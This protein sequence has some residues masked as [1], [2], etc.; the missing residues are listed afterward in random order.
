[1][2]KLFSFAI[3]LF[4][5]SYVSAQDKT[6]TMHEAVVGLYTN[7][8]SENIQQTT[9][10]PNEDAFTKIESLTDAPVLVKVNVPSM[11]TET[12]F[13]LTDINQSL[14]LAKE[15]RYIPQIHWFDKQSV[16]FKYGDALF[17]GAES[18]GEWQFK[19]WL[20]LPE[21]TT[22]YYV[23][24]ESKQVAYSKANNLM[25]ANA[26]GEKT[27]VTNHTDLNIVSGQIVSRNEF[28]VN[29]GVFFAPESNL[30]AFYQKD[31]SKVTNYPVINWQVVP[32]EVKMVK[33]PMAGQG[34]EEVHLG[35]YNPETGKTVFMQTGDHTDHYLTNITWGPEG[36]YI[37]IAILERSQD[38]L[39]LY[40]YDAQTGERVAK[41][42]EESDPKYVHP[43]EPLYFIPGHDNQFIWWSE[44]DGFMHL[45]RYNTKGKLLNTI[46]TGNYVVNAI[47]GWNA[48]ENEI[49]ISSAKVSA[50]NKNVY[51]V[52]WKNGKMRR[53]DH[54]KGVH[55]AN[56][57]SE[58]TY[59]IDRYTNYATPNKIRVAAVNSKWSKVLLDAENPLKDYAKPEIKELT[60]TAADGKTPLNARLILP[61]N[62][63]AS[64]KYP[65]IVYL[66][67]GPGVQLL[68]N[69]FPE[70]G[71]LWYDYMAQ[72]GYIIFTMDGRGSSNRGVAFEQATFR[73][74]GTVEME[75]QLEGVKYLKSLPY[76]DADRLGVHGWSFGGFMTTSL[77]LRHPGVFKV[78]VAGGPVMDW[79]M[80]EV[81]YTERYMDTPQENPEGYAK[82]NLL[83][84]VQNLEGKLLLIHGA[85]DST[86]VWQHS[87][88]FL[89]SCVD[90][91][92]QV[93]YF[94]YPDHPHNVRGFDRIHLMQKITDYFDEFLK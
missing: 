48:K 24:T 86:V 93:D 44:R 32:A 4:V 85:Q 57:N 37:Y 9:W 76:V 40:K 82:A 1:M 60:I 72:H 92:V 84:K 88:K 55:R 77:M 26:K 50:M 2:R 63:D 75:D 94:V 67:N 5:M 59:W 10:I 79:H 78:G 52:N 71:N 74:L 30:I 46:T 7:L 87:M 49:I 80:Y 33:Y 21:N 3:A 34:S 22:N 64:K 81:M 51:A 17:T 36:K 53:L 16:Y 14:N 18:N 15:L 65:V 70:S 42:L 31:E 8:A 11:T 25:L 90:E 73:Q 35:V 43:A 23:D 56:V 45:Y 19:K 13:S 66:Y 29:Q 12:I 62:F 20:E 58:G 41:L 6:Y 83:D 27:A 39:A 47:N 28:G 68:H 61:P 54:A 91:N 69:R 38:H 89:E